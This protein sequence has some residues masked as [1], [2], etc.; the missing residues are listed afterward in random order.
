VP[1]LTAHGINFV[2]APFIAAAANGLRT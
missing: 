2:D 1:I